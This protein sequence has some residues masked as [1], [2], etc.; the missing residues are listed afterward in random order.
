MQSPIQQ[1]NKTKHIGAAKFNVLEKIKNVI[2][3]NFVITGSFSLFQ[4]DVIDRQINDLDIVVENSSLVEILLTKF[5]GKKFVFS[6]YLNATEVIEKTPTLTCVYFVK[7]NM[8]F[9]PVGQLIIDG[10][11]VDLFIQ[12]NVEYQTINYWRPH[13]VLERKYKVALPKV[14]IEAKEN[15]LRS[16]SISL[17][18]RLKHQKDVDSY[19]NLTKIIL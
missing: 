11:K 7:D 1:Y 17:E 13:N 14:S 4:H 12:S 5:N 6:E 3:D 2:S 10:I 9:N 18:K 8:A 15:Y 16:I 19:Y